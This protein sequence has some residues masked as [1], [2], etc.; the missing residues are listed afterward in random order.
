MY[1]IR[2]T[3]LEKFRRFRDD[4]SSYDTEDSVIETLSGVFKGNEYTQIGTAFH[5]II[6]DGEA[7]YIGNDEFKLQSDVTVFMNKQQV[8][9]ALSYRNSLTDAFHEIRL[10]KN[11]HTP[12]FDANVTGCSDIIIGNIIHDIKTK[13]ST[14]Q[15]QEYIDSCQWRF[16]L[17]IF[18][19][20]QFVF[21]IFQL[22]GYDKEKHSLDVR[23]LT[24][25]QHEPIPCLR[26]SEME[27]DNQKL[28]NDFCEWIE[29]RK[30][31]HLLKLK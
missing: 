28:L 27:N 5:K 19:L 2:V 16:Y 21:D 25:I 30:L 17:E 15:Q 13:Y 22:K 26:Y 12:F 9:I 6:E 8:D 29:F 18:E 3:Q 7:L 11:Y 1:Q 20:D 31:H 24:M 4:V 10:D 23:Q 14:P